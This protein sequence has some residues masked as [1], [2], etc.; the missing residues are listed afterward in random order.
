M[1]MNKFFSVDKR[2]DAIAD[3]VR[4]ELKPIFAEIDRN[5]RV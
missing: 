2:L 4:N 1:K 5:N 3:E